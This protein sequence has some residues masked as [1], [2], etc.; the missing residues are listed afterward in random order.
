MEN[1]VECSPNQ[2]PFFP[3]VHRKTTFPSL[4]WGQDPRDLVLANEMWTGIIY[5]TSRLA[6]RLR[7]RCLLLPSLPN[8]C[9]YSGALRSQVLQTRE[10]LLF[11]STLCGSAWTVAHYIIPLRCAGYLL[12]QPAVSYPDRYPIL[13]TFIY[14]SRLHPFT[15][16]IFGVYLASSPLNLFT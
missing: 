9:Q 12:L 7:S 8:E 3:L 10:S 14:G 5:G 15:Q 13:W 16:D 1:Y 2:F 4:H 6:C 11:L